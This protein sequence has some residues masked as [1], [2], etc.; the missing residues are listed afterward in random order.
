MRFNEKLIQ[1][2]VAAHL[3]TNNNHQ[4]TEETQELK[5]NNNE[6]KYEQL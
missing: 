4:W 6:L 3:H 2:N 1:C 5:Y